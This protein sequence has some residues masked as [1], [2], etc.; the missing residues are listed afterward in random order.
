VVAL[1]IGLVPGALGLVELGL[2]GGHVG[3][4]RRDRRLHLGVLGGEPADL[5]VD[6]PA[7]GPHVVEPALGLGRIGRR[8][9]GIAGRRVEDRRRDRDDEAHPQQHR[10][11]TEPGHRRSPDCRRPK[12]PEM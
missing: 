2:L 5:Q 6:L 10:S 11:T 3:L 9:L 1:G 4:E 7:L 8:L 12:C